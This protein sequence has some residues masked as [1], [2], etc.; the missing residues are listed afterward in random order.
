MTRMSRS[1]LSLRR[2]PLSRR[3]LLPQRRAV[4]PFAQISG[5]GDCRLT[6][7]ASSPMQRLIARPYRSVSARAS[8][9]GSTLLGRFQLLL[10][11]QLLSLHPPPCR[12]LR[13]RPVN[14]SA[15]LRRQQLRR[16]GAPDHAQPIHP[17]TTHAFPSIFHSLFLVR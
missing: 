15:P 10:L 5:R 8:Q 2:P 17:N 14:V 3:L 12:R 7:S 4:S 9:A 6:R 11:L 1:P 16:R 13:R